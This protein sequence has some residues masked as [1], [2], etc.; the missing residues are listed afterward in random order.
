[1]TAKTTTSTASARVRRSRPS[2]DSCAIGSSDHRTERATS[3]RP[4]SRGRAITPTRRAPRAHRRRAPG[5]RTRTSGTGTPSGCRPAR[6]EPSNSSNPAAANARA[7]VSVTMAATDAACRRVASRAPPRRRSGVGRHIRHDRDELHERGREPRHHAERPAERD[8]ALESRCRRPRAWRA[9]ASSTYRGPAPSANSRHAAS[10]QA[11]MPDGV[12]P[13]A[14]S[15]GQREAACDEHRVAARGRGER[16]RRPAPPPRPRGRRAPR[17][18]TAYDD[19]AGRD[20]E[21]EQAARELPVVLE[22]RRGRRDVP[23]SD[24]RTSVPSV[25]TVVPSRKSA[26]RA[27][28]LDPARAS[29]KT[30]PARR[31]RTDREAV[32]AGQRPSRRAPAGRDRR[33]PRHRVA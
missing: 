9:S 4:R 22:R 5:G 6:C 33:A 21:L 12:A 8:R 2:A 1:M 17:A 28:R 24:A 31:E 18:V 20:R 25:A 19:V 26:A 27:S 13:S 23:S 32:P 29:S 30:S 3:G 11:V 14:G 15:V 10:A 7:C 16:P